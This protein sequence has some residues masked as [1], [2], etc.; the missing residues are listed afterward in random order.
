MSVCLSA[1]HMAF[2]D[3]S[4]PKWRYSCKIQWCDKS[5]ASNPIG[6]ALVCN[7]YISQTSITHK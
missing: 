3:K 6:S 4:A 2:M 7:K 5:Q 1:F